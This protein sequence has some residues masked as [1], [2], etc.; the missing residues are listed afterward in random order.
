M[1]YTELAGLSCQVPPRIQ[2]WWWAVPSGPPSGCA[3]WPVRV[4]FGDMLPRLLTSPNGVRCLRTA[5]LFNVR[6]PPW[7]AHCTHCFHLLDCLTHSWE[8]SS[9]AYGPISNAY[10]HKEVTSN[11]FRACKF[12]QIKFRTCA[13][14][15]SMR[16]PW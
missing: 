13:Q 15:F 2:I 7:F 9:G 1:K 14:P 10:S 6:V 8:G 12:M 5:F 16:L 3:V 11:E 4:R